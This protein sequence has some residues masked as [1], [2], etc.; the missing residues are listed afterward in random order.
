MIVALVGVDK[1]RDAISEYLSI[2][3]YSN[4]EGRHFWNTINK[5]Q[6]DFLGTEK[7]VQFFCIYTFF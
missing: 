1:M 7:I 6:Y 2:Y 4:A 5:V 3:K